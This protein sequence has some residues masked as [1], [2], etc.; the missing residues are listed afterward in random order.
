MCFLTLDE[1]DSGV[2]Y[3]Y[4]QHENMETVLDWINLV[5]YTKFNLLQEKYQSF[6]KDDLA[7][8]LNCGGCN[9]ALLV[10]GHM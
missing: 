9:M 5:L 2:T 7:K 3:T 6:S 1:N 10:V 4:L 8:I